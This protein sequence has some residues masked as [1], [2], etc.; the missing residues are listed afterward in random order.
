[1]TP[2]E[3]YYQVIRDLAEPS[4]FQKKKRWTDELREV[5]EE[6][7]EKLAGLILARAQVHRKNNQT[8]LA[9]ALECLVQ[10]II[11]PKT[12]VQIP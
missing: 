4:S 8:S 10:E 9:E 5:V 2:E 12:L 3:R 1:M 7:R 6:D 11:S